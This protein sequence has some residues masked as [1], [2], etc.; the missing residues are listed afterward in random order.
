MDPPLATVFRY[1]HIQQNPII[2]L[3][4][5]NHISYPLLHI[6]DFFFQ[7]KK[8]VFKSSCA[9]MDRENPDTK[10]N[11]IDSR[12]QNIKVHHI[13][14]SFSCKHLERIHEPLPQSRY[15]HIIWPE[16]T[17]I[18]YFSDLFALYPVGL[19]LYWLKI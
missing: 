18:R 12:Q 1:I 14:M 10:I 6:S 15:Q 19:L 4:S 3:I 16:R 7:L 8:M 17:H 9:K 11:K 13:I 2:V 5:D